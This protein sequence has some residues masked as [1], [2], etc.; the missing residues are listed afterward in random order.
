MHAAHE[1]ATCVQHFWLCID[2]L[3]P[4][5]SVLTLTMTVLACC[6][7]LPETRISGTRTATG[8]KVFSRECQYGLGAVQ[9]MECRAE[10]A[11]TVLPF[12]SCL[13]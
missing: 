11:Q 7:R 12:H 13:Y 8:C 3:Y 10:S 9:G 1:R 4:F 2:L 5:L 6:Y